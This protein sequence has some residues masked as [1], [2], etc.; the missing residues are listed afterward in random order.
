MTQQL[1]CSAIKRLVPASGFMNSGRGFPSMFPRNL[2]IPSTATLLIIML[3][4][5]LFRKSA[6]TLEEMR[7]ILRL[8][9]GHE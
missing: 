7:M 6:N 4:Q 2:S 5:D 1:Q 9:T 8:A 3:G